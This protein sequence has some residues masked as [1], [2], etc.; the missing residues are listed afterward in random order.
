MRIHPDDLT[1][2]GLDDGDTAMC[3]SASGQIEVLL[4]KDDTVQ[5]GMVTLPHGYGMVYTDDSGTL[6]QNGPSI[7]VLTSTE[8]CDPIAKTPFHK[9]VSVAIDRI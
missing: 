7:N 2:L 1:S 6:K 4:M 8:H 3:R 5:P 9:H